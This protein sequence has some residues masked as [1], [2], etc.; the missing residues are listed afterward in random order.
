MY[1]AKLSAKHHVDP[2][3]ENHGLQDTLSGEELIYRVYRKSLEVASNDTC[4]NFALEKILGMS[5]SQNLALPLNS[6]KRVLS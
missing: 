5:V 2:D 4:F 1:P 3:N 6:S